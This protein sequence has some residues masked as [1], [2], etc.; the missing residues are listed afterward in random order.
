MIR[1]GRRGRWTV[2][3][4]VA[5]GFQATDVPVLGQ[6]SAERRDSAGIV[7]VVNTGPDLELPVRMEEVL[8][9]YGNNDG[10]FSFGPLRHN[11]V[12]ADASWQYL[13]ALL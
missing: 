1:K 4:A 12:S 8:R 10:P 7:I 3:F 11:V 13:R 2:F 9:L 6:V 5:V